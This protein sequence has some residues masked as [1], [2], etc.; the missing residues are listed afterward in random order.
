MS[1]QPCISVTFL[2]VCGSQPPKE[3]FLFPVLVVSR[4]VFVPLL[5]FCN[6]QRRSYFPVLFSHDAAFAFIMMLFSLSSGYCVCLS[7][8]YA[9]Q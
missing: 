1:I 7:M 2:S 9:P 6:V 3:S 8:T 5:M 4:V